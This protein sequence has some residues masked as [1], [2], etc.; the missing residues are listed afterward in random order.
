MIRVIILD[1]EQPSVDKLEKLLKESG[2]A[3]VKGKFTK[4][5]EA[6]EFLKTS[7]IDAIFLDIEM[8]DM[9]GIELSNRI[10]DLQEKVAF[11]FV[12]AYSQYAVE[13]FRLN[14]LD[15]LMKPITS[16]R[17]KETLDRIVEERNLGIY[18]SKPKVQCFGKFKVSTAGGEVKFRT[19]KA[20]ELLAFLI[21]QRG[22][23]VSRSK[24]I[25]CL[26]EEYEGDRAL[27][28]FNTTLHYVKKALVVHGIQA[29]IEYDRGS[30]RFDIRGLDCDYCRFCA[31]TAQP[32][33]INEANASEYEET[34]RLY[35]G[36]YLSDK[37]FMWVERS[38]Q[39]LKDQF[40]DI[41][42][43]LSDYYKSLGMYSKIIEYM[44]MGLVH[45]T[46]HREIN[47]RLVA[48]LLS[49]NDRIS[50]N[51]YYDIYTKGLMKKLDQKPDEDF[52]KLIRHAEVY[53]EK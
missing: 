2:M 21:D 3:E 36:D 37:E 32:M 39:V 8:P 44:K 10:L 20:E 12:T 22:S 45:E 35:T 48:A 38:R 5:L 42:I 26:W 30:Y 50:A 43:K 47:Y 13:A 23:F 11:V 14:A 25:D 1:D 31:A 29:P 33:N 51:Q 34:A 27:I 4:P 18:L 52:K 46:L 16:D 9:D 15:Y 19:E 28:H 53:G 24:I 7:K 49:T 6:L 40:F 17:L 41:L